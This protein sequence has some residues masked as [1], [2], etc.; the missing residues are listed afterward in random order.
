M[1]QLTGIQAAADHELCRM[2]SC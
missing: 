1:V 2:W